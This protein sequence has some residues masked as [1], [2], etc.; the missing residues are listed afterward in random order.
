MSDE[1]PERPGPEAILPA[2]EREARDWARTRNRALWEEPALLA[3]VGGRAP[4]LRVLDLGC[5]SGQPIAEWF[6]RRGDAV[7]G[8]D[9]AA[10]MIAEFRARV[11]GAEAVLADMRGLALGPRFDVVIAFNS[12]FHL[13]PDDQRAMIAV[14]AAH[15]ARD[16]TLLFT[17][18][19]RAGEAWGRV[20]GSAVY[21]A[22]LDP[23]EY[24]ALLDGNGFD[25]LWFRPEDAELAGHSV[26]LARRK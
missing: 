5:G 24:R 4:G 10:A 21:H 20:G 18:G 19:P 15:A 13:S 3:A 26:W 14:F 6:D 16:A 2:Y 9:G 23:A 22:S 12:V 17:S 1:D 8:V 7:T 11:P 25:V